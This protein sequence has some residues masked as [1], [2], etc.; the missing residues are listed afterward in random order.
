MKSL[1]PILLALTLN[2]APL[3]QPWPTRGWN[4]STPEA[5]GMDSESPA[6]VLDFI[7]LHELPVHS[8]LVVRNRDLRRSPVI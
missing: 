1:L 5:Q 4:S 2:A 3:N 6:G 7:R 8:L